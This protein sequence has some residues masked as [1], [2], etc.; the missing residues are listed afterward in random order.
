MWSN[1]NLHWSLPILWLKSMVNSNI[2]TVSSYC[3]YFKESRKNE[4]NKEK[5]TGVITSVLADSASSES[6]ERLGF[7]HFIYSARVMS[8]RHSLEP[9][10]LQVKR[11]LYFCK[12]WCGSLESTKSTI[13]KNVDSTLANVQS[14]KLFMASRKKLETWR[15]VKSWVFN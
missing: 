10:K 15:G 2:Q 9:E 12:T 3:Q 6:A 13:W 14:N 4:T 11:E 1:G 5:N 8:M 7:F